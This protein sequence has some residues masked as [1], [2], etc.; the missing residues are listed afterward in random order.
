MQVVA[1]VPRAIGMQLKHAAMLNQDVPS[2]GMRVQRQ[3]IA[4]WLAGLPA[5]L[6]ALT[7]EAHDS[8]GCVHAHRTLHASVS[9]A[10]EAEFIT[11][12]LPHL[13]P[14]VAVKLAVCCAR[15]QVATTLP[16]PI[17]VRLMHA[18]LSP[19]RLKTLHLTF[20]QRRCPLTPPLAALAALADGLRR[21]TELGCL[22][23]SAAGCGDCATTAALAQQI[24]AQPHLTHLQLCG[25]GL[26]VVQSLAP[27]LTACTLAWP[28]GIHAAQ[29]T[30]ACGA[31]RPKR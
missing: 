2:D 14:L 18:A 12:V 31:E 7:Y 9:D 30:C 6:Q 4:A 8:S 25:P 21:R 5:H 3:G 20:G 13:P 11:R 28:C 10:T 15:R 29:L 27:T 23:L 1:A 24:C 26:K 16:E 17:L 22:L 19:E